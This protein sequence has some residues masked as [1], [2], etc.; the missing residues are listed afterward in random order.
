LIILIVVLVLGDD[1]ILC[2]G[3]GV[4]MVS[5]ISLI[6]FVVMISWGGLC[7]IVDLG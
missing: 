1:F 2:V 3:I 6:S 7:D 5:S 4:G